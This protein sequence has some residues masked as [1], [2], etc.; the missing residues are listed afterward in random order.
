MAFL[1]F[2][3]TLE[4]LAFFRRMEVAGEGRIITKAPN[5]IRCRLSDAFA[6]ER[7]HFGYDEDG[8][9]CFY[10]SDTLQW[11]GVMPWTGVYSNTNRTILALACRAEINAAELPIKSK[12]STGVGLCLDLPCNPCLFRQVIEDEICLAS[13]RVVNGVITPSHRIDKRIPVVL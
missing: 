12:I 7:F 13:F 6:R 9:T 10:Y 3:A 11:V 1:T 2:A 5:I 8:S 4:A